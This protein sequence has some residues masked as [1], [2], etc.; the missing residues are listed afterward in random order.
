[1]KHTNLFRFLFVVYCFAT[2]IVALVVSGFDFSSFIPVMLLI[3]GTIFYIIASTALQV[4]HKKEERPLTD[5]VLVILYPFLVYYLMFFSFDFKSTLFLMFP[6]YFYFLVITGGFILG[7]FLSPFMAARK[8]HP[9]EKIRYFIL[10]GIE[11]IKN[12]GALVYAG[13]MFI[14][15]FAALTYFF[16]RFLS[17]F[18]RW[19]SLQTAFFYFFLFVGIIG[20]IKFT[21]RHTSFNIARDPELRKKYTQDE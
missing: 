5:L 21:Y 15:I 20:V 4:S 13:I 12:M 2:L 1:M 16:T 9:N 7:I 8:G 17:R 6:G 11:F 3:I 14:G 19:S 18:T 10:E